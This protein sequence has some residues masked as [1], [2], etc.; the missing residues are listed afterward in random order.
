MPLQAKLVHS[1]L[2]E[3]TRRVQDGA[4]PA[5]G[6]NHQ[7]SRNNAVEARTDEQRLTLNWWQHA[8][9]CNAGTHAAQSALEEP[10]HD[11]VEIMYALRIKM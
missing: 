2:P 3:V 9:T 7:P 1:E 8:A 11:I 4:H 10:W 5:E 6:S